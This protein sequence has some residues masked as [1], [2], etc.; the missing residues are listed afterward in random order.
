[1][2]LCAG[3]TISRQTSLGNTLCGQLYEKA[4]TFNTEFSITVN[5]VKCLLFEGEMKR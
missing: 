4:A 5:G 1:V 2:Q 3:E